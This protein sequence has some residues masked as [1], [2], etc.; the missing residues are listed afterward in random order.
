VKLLKYGSLPNSNN[1]FEFGR[2]VQQLV[3]LATALASEIETLQV[4]LATAQRHD[5]R[6]NLNSR[7]T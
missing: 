3:Q 2:K 5:G 1:E 6:S 7:N 4:E